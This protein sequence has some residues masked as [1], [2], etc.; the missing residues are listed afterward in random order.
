MHE[1]EFIEAYKLVLEDM[2]PFKP[3]YKGL[4]MFSILGEWTESPELLSFPKE[5]QVELCKNLRK[6]HDSI[7]FISF[8]KIIEI[9]EKHG[10]DYADDVAEGLKK[11]DPSG[12]GALLLISAD[13]DENEDFR[14]NKTLKFIKD[15]FNDIYDNAYSVFSEVY[16]NRKADGLTVLH[17]DELE[18]GNAYCCIFLSRKA[19]SMKDT[20]E[21]ELTHFIKNVA[22]HNGKFPKTYSEVTPEKIKNRRYMCIVSLN[23]L[24]ASVGLSHEAMSE[25]DQ[26]AW[27]AFTAR[28]EQPT[29]KSIVNAFIRRY[30][31]DKSF[32]A[33]G[34]NVLKVS[35]IEAAMSLE[36][37]ESF[38]LSWIRSLLEK[39]SSGEL[40]K[41]SK[42]KLESYFFAAYREKDYEI[43]FLLKCMSY[44]C[45]KEQYPEYKIESIVEENFKKFKFRDV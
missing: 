23:N 10:Y 8:K 5:L 13:V 22:S 32:H 31:T 4:N 16:N 42:D 2:S 28:E 14:E 21:H 38:R 40:F 17:R 29:I 9:L 19:F 12:H 20:L 24:L 25:I 44:Y 11:I 33:I 35:Q 7:S 15:N 26:I 36:E 37:I 30:E 45:F 18:P 43:E 39:I 3:S 1:D 34:H 41:E 27:R 6:K